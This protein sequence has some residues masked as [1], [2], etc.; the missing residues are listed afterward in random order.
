MPVF[1]NCD[2]RIWFCVVL[3]TSCFV[4]SLCGGRHLTIN[5][6]AFYV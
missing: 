1:L 3:L 5:I 2:F 6:E 4:G